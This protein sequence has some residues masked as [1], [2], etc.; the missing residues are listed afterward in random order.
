MDDEIKSHCAIKVQAVGRG[1]VARVRILQL[2]KTR[3]EKIFDPRRNEYYYYDTKLDISSW[4]KPKLLGDSDIEEIAQTYTDE[5]AVVMIQRQLMRRSALRKVRMLYQKTVTATYDEGYEATYYFNP[6]TEHTAWE[7]PQFMNHRIDYTYDDLP[8]GGRRPRE[9]DDSST[10]E[11]KDEDSDLSV[12]SEIVRS[13][14]REKRRYPRSKSQII[15]DV[16]EDNAR[17]GLRN[18]A[19]IH[20]GIDYRVS[21]RIFDL[22]NLVSLKLSHNSLR[23]LSTKVEYLVKLTELDVSHNL[24]TQLPRQIAD[25]SLLRLFNASY[26]RFRKFTGFLYKCAKLETVNLEGNRLRRL[27]ITVGNLELLK[28]TKQWEVG[29]GVLKNLKFLNLSKNLF[30]IWPEQIERNGKLQDLNLSN[31]YLRRVPILIRKNTSLQVLDLSNNLLRSVPTA[32]YSLPLRRLILRNNCLEELPT[33]PPAITT[34]AE[35]RYDDHVMRQLIFLDVSYNR[36]GS[37]GEGGQLGFFGAGL[38]KLNAH[39][40]LIESIDMKGLGKL[41]GLIELNVARNKIGD[42]FE[43]VSSALKTLDMSENLLRAIPPALTLAAGL[44][45]L[46]LSCNMITKIPERLFGA[47]VLI[48]TLDLHNNS[49]PSLPNNLFAL[50]KIQYIDLSYNCISQPIPR[51]LENFVELRTLL[52]S[53]NKITELPESIGALT[54]LEVLE[55]EENALVSFPD[56]GVAQLKSLQRVTTKMNDIKIRPWSLFEIPSLRSWDMSWNRDIICKYIDWDARERHYQSDK[57]VASLD[58]MNVLLLRANRKAGYEPLERMPE[59]DILVSPFDYFDAKKDDEDRLKCHKEDDDER[60]KKQLQEEDRVRKA[61]PEAAKKKKKKKP[62]VLERRAA[63]DL[64]EKELNANDVSNSIDW[65]KNFILFFRRHLARYT[66]ENSEAMTI[67]KDDENQRIEELQ[68]M[69]LKM[70]ERAT[71]SELAISLRL[72]NHTRAYSGSDPVKLLNLLE[73]N[74]DSGIEVF[75]TNDFNDVPNLELVQ[76]H[77]LGYRF[78]D[79]LTLFELVIKELGV[80]AAVG[81]IESM[82]RRAE[83]L[84]EMYTKQWGDK[85]GTRIGTPFRS[86]TSQKSLLVQEDPGDESKPEGVIEGASLLTS[87]SQQFTARTNNSE[88]NELMGI[89]LGDESDDDEEGKEMERVQTAASRKYPTLEEYLLMKARSHTG[90]GFDDVE[91]N[92]DEIALELKSTVKSTHLVD[93]SVGPSIL[94]EPFLF[95]PEIPTEKCAITRKRLRLLAFKA[96]FGMGMALLRRIDAMTVSIR[97]LENRGKVPVSCLDVAQRLGL[98]YQ[99]LVTDMI[100]EVWERVRKEDGKAQGSMVERKNQQMQ[101]LMSMSGA[102]DGVD[103][104]LDNE[105]VDESAGGGGGDKA[106]AAAEKEKKKKYYQQMKAQKKDLADKAEDERA[107]LADDTPS[108]TEFFLNR[109]DCGSI[110]ENEARAASQYIFKLRNLTAIWAAQVFDAAS[111]ILKME[112]WD[113]S[114]ISA[115]FADDNSDDEDDPMQGGGKS[116]SKGKAPFDIKSRAAWEVRARPPAHCMGLSPNSALTRIEVRHFYMMRARSLQYSGRTMLAVTQY[117]NVLALGG[118]KKALQNVE[119]ELIRLYL[120]EKD[121]ECAERCLIRVIHGRIED[122]DRKFPQPWQLIRTHPLLAYWQL[123]IAE[124]LQM[125]RYSGFKSIR[126]SM[127]FSQTADGSL[128]RRNP[129]KESEVTLTDKELLQKREVAEAL[130]MKQQT[131]A[132]KND[133][134]DAALLKAQVRRMI[135]DYRQRLDVVKASFEAMNTDT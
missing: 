116:D 129:I 91:V 71:S 119:L 45:T 101:S 114:A 132:K 5:E 40:N 125:Q 59:N 64:K 73:K 117:N 120:K 28:A 46:N 106:A 57:D 127:T 22:T 122:S 32:I 50:R 83:F 70:R 94:T 77:D 92:W 12:D 84:R 131:K 104:D 19:V 7:L 47:C 29:F 105:E 42:A 65:Q 38:K 112:G 17:N 89:A 107:A 56:T 78:Q 49:I 76:S 25:L 79:A 108:T 111:D 99:D 124:G 62:T 115:S 98:D 85:Y 23:K 88:A 66:S 81:H 68:S 93:Y 30:A 13:R 133:D 8:L 6:V 52:L 4:E 44:E 95:A 9:N 90:T 123:L 31:N 48:V 15:V 20:C 11:E 128:V 35:Y 33:F 27:P 60:Y 14:R 75:A 118:N 21:D 69:M 67:R 1:Y 61:D 36:L 103:L 54:S 34:S 74:N 109:S 110:T 16:A 53:H 82:M 96:Y 3:F 55:L 43:E 39:D 2:I 87:R 37:L 134:K 100:E 51:L 130:A 113:I 126:N 58:F 24:L 102:A 63:L 10:E 18:L 86:L 41:T 80:M 121:Y 72:N 26:N 135:F 97:Q